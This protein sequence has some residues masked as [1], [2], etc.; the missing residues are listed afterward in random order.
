MSSQ[1][2]PLPNLVAQFNGPLQIG[3]ELQGLIERIERVLRAIGFGI[4]S[5]QV[6][7]GEGIRGVEGDRWALTAFLK[8][9]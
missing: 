4:G 2:Q 5:P 7:M 9:L 1:L 6:A 8:V 3:I